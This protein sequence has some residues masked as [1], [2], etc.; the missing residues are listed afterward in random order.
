MAVNPRFWLKF[1]VK[2]KLNKV[3]WMIILMLKPMLD[4]PRYIFKFSWDKHMVFLSNITVDQNFS[5]K[6]EKHTR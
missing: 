4:K 5:S 6:L 2:Y 1:C 3:A